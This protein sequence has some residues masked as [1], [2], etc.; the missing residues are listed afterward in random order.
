MTDRHRANLAVVE[1][2][3]ADVGDNA[4]EDL[5]GAL[6]I[7]VPIPQG[8]GPLRRVVGDPHHLM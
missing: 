6:E 3:V 4:V 2:L 8:C 1:T 7:D 5:A